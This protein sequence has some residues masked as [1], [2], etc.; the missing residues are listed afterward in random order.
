MSRFVALVSASMFGCFIASAQASFGPPNAWSSGWGQGVSEYVAN[1]NDGDYLYIA[2][3]PSSPVTMSLNV[4]EESYGTYSDKDFS[5]IIDGQEIE[6]PYFTGSRVHAN[7]FYYVLE[8]MRTA[9]TIVGLTSD[10]IQVELPTK[11]AAE[12][13]PVFPSEN[14]PCRTEF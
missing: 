5:L 13:L 14:F 6:T 12:A 8:Q 2:C 1:N 10:G 11:G 7:N 4:G 3:D 9:E